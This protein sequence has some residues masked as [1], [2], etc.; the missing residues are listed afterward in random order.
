MGKC[1]V[2]LITYRNADGFKGWG[3]MILRD[4]WKCTFYYYLPVEYEILKGLSNV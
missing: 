2:T 4:G 3:K 1:G